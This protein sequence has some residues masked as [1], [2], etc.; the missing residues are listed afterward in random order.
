MFNN[1]IRTLVQYG[2]IILDSV[3][4]HLGKN[5]LIRPSNLDLQGC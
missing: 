1:G 2:S 3:W 4:N 5:K